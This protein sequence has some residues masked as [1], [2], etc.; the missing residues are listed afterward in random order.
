[1]GTRTAT[2]RD[3]KITIRL[4]NEEM[5]QLDYMM[6]RSGYLSMSKYIRTKC[7][8]GRTSMS[9]ESLADNNSVRS[10]V[11]VLSAEISKIGAN[12]NLVIKDFKNLLSQTKKDGSPVINT[13][14]STYYMQ[15]LYAL[16]LEVKT[17]VQQ[18][19]EVVKKEL[20][21]STKV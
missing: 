1:M 15:Q 5:E 13:S 8:G 11:N 4:S 3:H 16:T 6:Q 14:T 9:P 12:Y 10:Q 20:K 17:L 2:H 19:I 21:E 7:L 18:F